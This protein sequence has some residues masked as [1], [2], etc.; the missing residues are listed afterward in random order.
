MID[1]IEYTQAYSRVVANELITGQQ[2][3]QYNHYPDKA[4]VT[5]Y[6]DLSGI[7]SM[8]WTGIHLNKR[9]PF[10]KML[11][12]FEERSLSVKIQAN[13]H[14]LKCGI[15]FAVPLKEA[16]FFDGANKKDFMKSYAEF[17]LAKAISQ[18]L[19]RQGDYALAEELRSRF[20]NPRHDRDLQKEGLV[21][22]VKGCVDRALGAITPKKK[23]KRKDYR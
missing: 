14:A 18:Q 7:G 13:P 8:A 11:D 2:E 17:F 1:E 12:R 22:Q 21:N 9:S 4:L 20:E 5:I 3:T 10:A 19:D 15:D 16:E 6:V 23:D